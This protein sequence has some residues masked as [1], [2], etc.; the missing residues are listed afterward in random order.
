MVSDQI[1]MSLYHDEDPTVRQPMMKQSQQPIRT[2]AH[3]KYFSRRQKLTRDDQE[4]H[5]NRGQNT[6][7]NQAQGTP[8]CLDVRGKYG[9]LKEAFGAVWRRDK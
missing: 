5:L 6:E 1:Y 7:N 4:A 9:T 2:F 3:N 8:R